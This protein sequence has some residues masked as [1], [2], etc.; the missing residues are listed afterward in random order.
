MRLD[1]LPLLSV[2]LMLVVSAAAYDFLPAMMTVHWNLYLQPDGF[3]RKQ[4][5]VLILPAIGL[6]V[7]AMQLVGRS[8]ASDGQVTIQFGQAAR[9]GLPV[10]LIAHVAMIG[11]A[12]S[13]SR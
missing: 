13:S 6:L 12:L 7:V 10:L 11:F 4:F 3:A 5:A 9:V 1:Y 8:V 2:A